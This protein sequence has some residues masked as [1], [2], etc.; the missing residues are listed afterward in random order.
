MNDTPSKDDQLFMQ[1]IFTFQSAAWQ[2]LGKVKNPMTDK[3][4]R[5]LDQA[6]FAIDILDMLQRKTDGNVV[7][8]LKQVLQRAV[9]ELQMNY[10]A[11]AGKAEAETPAKAGPAEEPVKKEKEPDSKKSAPKKKAAKKGGSTKKKK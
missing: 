8:P 7:D 4:E 3:V 5:N 9:S 1:L 6:R 2:A 10:V 11:E